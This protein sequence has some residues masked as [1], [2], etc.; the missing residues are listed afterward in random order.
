MIT[1]VKYISHF[2][3][4][5]YV[6]VVIKSAFFDIVSWPQLQDGYNAGLF[7]AHYNIKY[8]S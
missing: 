4:L 7:I 1:P 3:T 8:L 5:G 6:S 2:M